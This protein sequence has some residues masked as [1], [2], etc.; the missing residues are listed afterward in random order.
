M[1]NIQHGAAEAVVSR[2]P[3]PKI[4]ADCPVLQIQADPAMGIHLFDDFKNTSRGKALENTTLLQIAGDINWYGFTEGDLSDILVTADD[5][6]ALKID[7]DGT[8]DDIVGIVTGDNLTGI[9]RSPK[10]GERK[11]FWFEVRFQVS[12]VTDTDL[13]FFIGLME[14]GKLA[15]T[16]PLAA[17]PTAP[18]SFDYFGFFVAEADGNDLTIVYEEPGAGSPVSDTGEITLT[19]GAY[20]RVGF[21]LDVDTDKLHVYVDGVDQGA[22]AEIDISSVNFPSN[23][24]MDV[25]IVLTSGNLG[26]DGDHLLVDWIRVAQEY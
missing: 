22:D 20:V 16:S 18:T 2:M 19:A 23:T 15:T 25:Y 26:E 9:I 1:S 11:R 8:N 24:N 4:W 17:A 13:S 12:T 21:R 7:Q 6:G 14:P 10:K 5:I 3:S